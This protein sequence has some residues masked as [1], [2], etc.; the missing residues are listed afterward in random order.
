MKTEEAHEQTPMLGDV[1]ELMCGLVGGEVKLE[2]FL[3]G[4]RI[5]DEEDGDVHIPIGHA[6]RTHKL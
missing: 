2:V 5:D 3:E 4:R 1:V 6:G